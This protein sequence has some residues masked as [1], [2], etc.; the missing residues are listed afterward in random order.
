[1]CAGALPSA[2]GENAGGD[3]HANWPERFFAMIT[4]SYLRA[5]GLHEFALPAMIAVAT[6][7][8]AAREYP[9]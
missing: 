7:G 3:V 6:D 5:R 1:V 4:N 9:E 2:C 8:S